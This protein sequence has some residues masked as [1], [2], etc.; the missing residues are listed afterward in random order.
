[1]RRGNAHPMRGGAI[2]HTLANVDEE[3]RISLANCVHLA[4][5]KPA[6]AG[7]VR[8]ML[9]SSVG[10]EVSVSA[11]KSGVFLYT[12]TA[13]AAAAAQ[14]IAREVLFRQGLAADI[15][16]ERW[17]PSSGAWLSPGDGT[18]SELPSPQ[19]RGQ[20]RKRLRGAGAVIAAIIDGIGS[21]GSLSQTARPGAPTTPLRHEY[22]RPRTTLA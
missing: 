1:M 22:L 20:G 19:T 2:R 5:G 10:G 16:I 9:G 7:N 17:D 12:A 15:R 6:S 13:D 4:D 11:G 14:D 3:W 21:A 18:A 8:E